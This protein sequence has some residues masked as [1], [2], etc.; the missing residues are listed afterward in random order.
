MLFKNNVP[1]TSLAVWESLPAS[2][3]GGLGLIPDQGTKI[4]HP[5]SEAEILK[6]N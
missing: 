5:C 2:T 6:I 4:S 1:G 3:A